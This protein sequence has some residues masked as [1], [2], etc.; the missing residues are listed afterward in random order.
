MFRLIDLIAR[1]Y[2]GSFSYLQILCSIDLTFHIADDLVYLCEAPG[3]QLLRLLF[4]ISY[5]IDLTFRLLIMS[6]DTMAL[7]D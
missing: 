5:G 3:I 7:S 2:H 1:W 4:E 6:E